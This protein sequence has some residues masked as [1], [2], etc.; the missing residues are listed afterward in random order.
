MSDM[1][2]FGGAWPA[3]ITPT[4]PEGG[5]GFPALESLVEHLLTRKVDGLYICGSTGEGLLLSPEERRQVAERVLALVE[6]RVP[7]IVHVGC[8]A[9]RDAVALAT[10]A[11][12]AGA[13]GVSSVLP[14]IG[15]GMASTHLHY[16]AI[17]A[18][19]PD[20]P[21][22]PYLFGGQ[23]DAVTLMRSLLAAIPNLA[24]GK[25]TGSD[26]FELGRLLELRDEGWTVFSGMDEQCVFAAMFGAPGCIGSTLNLMPGLYRELRRSCAAGDLARALEL[27]KAANRVTAVLISFGFVGA[28]REAMR[29]IGLDCGQPRLPHPAV[30]DEKRQALHEA[31]RGAGLIEVAAL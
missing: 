17:A 23:T 21:F 29:L 20:L 30:P 4:T 1:R 9:T 7:V 19:V 24:G 13:A 16:Q 5:V 6:G 10:H 28:L 14:V 22:L 11:G 2:T 12:K 26:M 31:L 27:Q 3:L 15:T 18:A 25:Y 8:P